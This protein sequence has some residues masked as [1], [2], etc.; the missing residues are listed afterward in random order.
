MTVSFQSRWEQYCLGTAR[1]RITMCELLEHVY[2]Q[3]YTQYGWKETLPGINSKIHSS[4]V[5]E[6]DMY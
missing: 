3:L 1:E 4:G 6:Y 5:S 2:V